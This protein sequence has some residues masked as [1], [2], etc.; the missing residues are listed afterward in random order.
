VRRHR[1]IGSDEAMTRQRRLKRRI[2]ARM[3]KTGESYSTARREVLKR[4]GAGDRP[5][6]SSPAE[7]E[8]EGRL[9]RH[10]T[11]IGAVGLVLAVAVAAVVVIGGDG[12]GPKQPSVEKQVSPADELPQGLRELLVREHLDLDR[13]RSV[14]CGVGRQA[15]VELRSVFVPL[16]HARTIRSRSVQKRNAE[17]LRDFARAVHRGPAV[18][19]CQTEFRGGVNVSAK[20]GNTWV[21]VVALAQEAG[22]SAEVRDV[23][24]NAV[25]ISECPEATAAF[26]RAGVP[27]PTAYADKCPSQRRIE[28]LIPRLRR[29]QRDAERLAALTTAPG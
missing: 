21:K 28:E 9:R 16:I 4:L 3:A 6:P 12:E 17:R 5:A 7:P 22:S 1:Q 13:V 27:V 8:T 20:I 25:G 23:S 18:T 2:R 14:E 29:V 19:I 10:R 26:E 24:G 15:P 11:R